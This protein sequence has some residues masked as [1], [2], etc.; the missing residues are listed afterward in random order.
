MCIRDRL[1]TN[2]DFNASEMTRDVNAL[3]DLYGSQGYINAQV[4]ADPLFLDEPG[5]I[6]LVYKITEGKQYRVGRI[7]VRIDG[8]YGVTKQSVVLSRL[9]LRP[10][11]IIDV[12]KIRD[13]ERRLAASGLFMAEPAMAV[14]YT[15]LTLPTILLV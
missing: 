3:K 9:D 11:D 4:Q 8:D 6:D 14:S 10:G 12:R 5:M 7:N 1:Q 13:S 15:H 2:Q